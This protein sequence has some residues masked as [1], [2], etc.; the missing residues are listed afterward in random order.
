MVTDPRRRVATPLVTPRLSQPLWAPPAPS[1]P[2]RRARS[3]RAETAR[4]LL[5]VAFVVLVIVG[6]TCVAV[7]LMAWLS[8]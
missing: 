6:S 1:T 5:G 7:A 8:R 3:T 4:V 2:V